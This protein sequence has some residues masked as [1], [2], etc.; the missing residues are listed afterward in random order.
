VRPNHYGE[1][2]TED[3]VNERLKS[4]KQKGIKQ[5]ITEQKS[6]ASEEDRRQS[7]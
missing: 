4:S 1:A 2:L 7:G 5:E 3:D 6:E